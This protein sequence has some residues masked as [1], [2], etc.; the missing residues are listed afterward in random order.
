MSFLDLRLQEVEGSIEVYGIELITPTGQ[1]MAGFNSLSQGSSVVSSVTCAHAA[2]YQLFDNKPL[3]APMDIGSP[4]F[5][6]FTPEFVIKQNLKRAAGEHRAELTTEDPWERG[7][8]VD[9]W[10]SAE[11]S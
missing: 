5:L 11:F 6:G 2:K 1:F 3:R 4:Q 8:N 7:L 10:E 9:F